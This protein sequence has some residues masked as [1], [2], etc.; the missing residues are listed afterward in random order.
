MSLYKELNIS[1]N[2][3]AP[4]ND[5]ALKPQLDSLVTFTGAC[6]IHPSVLISLE[7]F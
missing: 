5:I 2:D 6:L 7:A 1:S 4:R 3:S